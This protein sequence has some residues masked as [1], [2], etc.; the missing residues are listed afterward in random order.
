VDLRSLVRGRFH[1]VG[2]S[3]FVCSSQKVNFNEMGHRLDTGGR[4]GRMRRSD[5]KSAWDGTHVDLRA[6]RS[7]WCSQELQNGNL[8]GI[9]AGIRSHRATASFAMRE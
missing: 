4:F 3:G 5:G 6:P 2:R 9:C 1:R 7:G 8:F